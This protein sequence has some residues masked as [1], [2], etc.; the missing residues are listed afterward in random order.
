MGNVKALEKAKEVLW[1]EYAAG[2]YDN[3]TKDL[4]AGAA[5]RLE[6]VIEMLT[7]EEEA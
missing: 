6:E 1:D 4:I 5:T 7:Y 3:P 2:G